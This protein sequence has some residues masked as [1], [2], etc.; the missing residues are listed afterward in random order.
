MKCFAFFLVT[1]L[2]ACGG[3]VSLGPSASGDSAKAGTGTDASTPGLE[4]AG[5]A[6]VGTP[7]ATANDAEP[8]GALPACS[9]PTPALPPDA[10]PFEVSANRAVLLCGPSTKDEAGIGYVNPTICLSA[11]A[12]ECTPVGIYGGAPGV[13]CYMNCSPCLMGCDANDYVI[14][15]G[16]PPEGDGPLFPLPAVQMPSGCRESMWSDFDSPLL[17]MPESVMNWHYY[18]CPCE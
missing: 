15:I 11:S 7:D 16:G 17:G 8:D 2:A 6:M 3:S 13:G 1:T 18:C 14:A 5:A 4:D 9:W 10:G 12:T